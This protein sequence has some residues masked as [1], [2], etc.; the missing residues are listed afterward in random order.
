MMIRI[1][2]TVNDSIVDGVGYRYT[3]FTQ[4]CPHHCPGCHNPQSHDFE[5]GRIVDTETIVRQV[6]ENPLLDGMTLSGGEPFC[7]P[8]ACR[9]LADAAHGLGLSVWCYTGYTLEK[10]MQEGDPARLALLDAV[11]VLVDGPFI[12]AQKSLELKFCG[13][14]NQRLIDMAKTRQSGQVTLWQPGGWDAL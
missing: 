9:V 2:G 12:L 4:G 1:A 8:E 10:L 14:R 5:G 3:V 6:R 7:Q 11:D 13:S